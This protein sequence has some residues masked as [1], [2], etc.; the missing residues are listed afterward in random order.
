MPA[1]SQSFRCFDEVARRG[2]VRKAAET[3]HLTPA[4]VNQ[5]V[6]NLEA[7][8]G[9]PLFDRM[10][11]GM[12]LTLAG[13]IMVASVRR[14]QRDFDHALA[15][16][17]DLRSLRRGHLNIGVSPSTAETLLPGV[18][19]QLFGS[20]PGLTFGVRS[21]NGEALLQWLANGEVDVAYCLR[22]PAPPGVQEV[23]AWP[24]QLG[25]VAAPG[26]PLLAEPRRALRLADCLDQ[27][28]VLMMPDTELRATLERLDARA[29]R[30]RR[31]AVETSSV[32]MVRRLVA[33]GVAVSFLIHENVADDVAAGRLGWRPLADA[34]ARLESCIYQRAG[35]TMPVAMGVLIDALENSVAASAAAVQAGGGGGSG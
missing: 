14:S 19:E 5:Q 31:P 9:V 15:Q 26:H 30:L 7:L 3:L 35:Y 13:E 12:K 1:I 16:V 20:Y 25:L 18:I 32:P 4:A 11:R 6:L 17:E 23:R 27:R 24:Q 10:P 8:V 33:T 22:R 28:L 2:S 29:Q 34:G 21:G